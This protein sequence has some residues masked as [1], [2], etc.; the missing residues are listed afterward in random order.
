M[1][2]RTRA[3]L[4]AAL[5]TGVGLA[6]L[7]LLPRGAEEA[8]ARA[9]PAAAPFLQAVQASGFVTFGNGTCFPDVVLH[10]CDGNAIRQLKGPGGAG[11]FTPYL[12]KWVTVSGSEQSCPSG[13]T[14]L[15]VVTIGEETSPCGQQP[16]ATATAI[17]PPSPTAVLPPTST[18]DPAV[19]TATPGTGG[20]NLALNK[21]VLASTTQAG[22][23]P[24]Q[25]VDGNGG[26]FWA[27]AAGQ[28]DPWN[29]ARNTQWIYVDLGQE[30]ATT[31]MRVT[32]SANRHARGYIIYRWDESRR[33]WISAGSTSHGDGDDDWSVRGGGT[34][35]GRYFMLWLVNPYI[36]GS[37][38][39]LLEWEIFDGTGGGAPIVNEAQGKPV[40]VLNET[41]GYLGAQAVDGDPST[42][43]RPTGLPSWLYVDLGREIDVDRV[44]LRWAAGLHATDYLLYVW[45]NGAWATAHTE[46]SGNGGEDG[47]SLNGRRT[48]YVLLYANAGPSS[49]VGLQELEVYEKGSGGS[50][51]LVTPTPNIPPPPI[52]FGGGDGFVREGAPPA[53]DGSAVDA[54]DGLD[55]APAGAPVPLPHE[56]ARD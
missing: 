54:L 48:Q 49:T 20:G 24:E 43:W 44:V 4:A 9:A 40:T 8:P 27:S 30:Y 51:G 36:M 56:A 29:R 10:D 18:P 7:G 22:Y 3:A 41:A 39:E 17:A 25:A 37:H 6:V 16:T 38:Y 35:D 34:V 47:I 42:E 32:F 5:L 55:E 28:D 26:T 52:P 53:R 46:R 15:N 19:P 21:P 50:P 12:D 1:R 14:F 31:G 23:P 33:N 2:R 45:E 11:F 13:D